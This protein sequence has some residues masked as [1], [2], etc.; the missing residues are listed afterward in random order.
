MRRANPKR[1][2]EEIDALV[3]NQIHAIHIMN[4]QI[5]GFNKGKNPTYDIA[6]LYVSL[7]PWN[8]GKDGS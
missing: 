8:K 6:H 4:I 1:K 2:D 7:F 5:N 3:Y